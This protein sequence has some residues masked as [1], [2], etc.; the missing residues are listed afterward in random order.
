MVMPKGGGL[1]PGGRADPISPNLLLGFAARCSKHNLYIF[2]LPE[3]RL[4]ELSSVASSLFKGRANHRKFDD[5]R[6]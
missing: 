5:L 3:P 6:V 1:D 4:V 2:S